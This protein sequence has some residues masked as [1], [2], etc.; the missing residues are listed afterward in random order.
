M[1]LKG[2]F[3]KV[4]VTK[5]LANKTAD[6]IGDVVES[7]RYHEADIIHEKRHIPDV[8]YGDPASFARYGSAEKYY[9]DSY[10]YIYSSYPYDGSLAEKLEW[11]N[12]GSYLDLHVFENEYPRTHGF[13]KFSYPTW[14]TVG[15]SPTWAYSGYGLPSATSKYEYI[16]LKGGPHKSGSTP[17]SQ[18]ANVWDPSN[19]RASNLELNLKKGTSVEFWLQKEAFDTDNSAKEVVFDLWNNEQSQSSDYGRFRV[20]LTGASAEPA[21]LLTV[22][23]GTA[24]VQWAPI[25][26]TLSS[27]VAD[28]KWHHYAFSAISASAGINVKYYVDGQLI[29]SVLTGS[30]GINAVSGAMTARIGSLIESP[31]GSIRHNHTSLATASYGKL[32]ASLDEFRYWKKKRSSEKIGRYW[33]TQVGGGTNT[34]YANVDLGVYYKFNE[35]I[36]GTSSIDSAVLDYSGRVTN[37][38]WTGYTAGART[39]GSA[40]IQ[41]S[42]STTEFKDP[43]M[44]PTHPKV[45]A[46]LAR[47]LDSGS[48]HDSLNPS[49]IFSTFPSWMQEQDENTTN[50][51]LKK[52]TQIISSYF[53]S[54]HL[55]IEEFGNLQDVRYASGSTKPNTLANR[56]L[57]SRGLHAPELFLDADIL[58]KLGDRSET[59][60][61]QESLTDVKNRIYQNIYNNLLNIYKSKGTR[62]SFRNVLRCY[63]VDEEI[64][65][66]NVYGNNISYEVRSNRELDSIK[67]SF[68]DFS[69]VDKHS[70]TIYQSGSGTAASYITGSNTLLAGFSTT[71]EAYAFF[72]QKP[73]PYESSFKYYEFAPLSSSLFG[74]HSIHPNNEATWD[75]TDTTNFEVYAV[76][77]TANSTDAQFVLT[78]SNGKVITQLTSSFYDE[79][80]ANSNWVFGVTVKPEKSPSANFVSGSVHPNKYILEFK[81]VNVEAG[82]VLESFNVSS[83]YRI[84]AAGPVT[85]RLITDS[86]KIYAGAHRTNFTGTLLNKSDVRIGF[87]R[88]WL[89]DL[90][91][92]EIEDHGKDVQNYGTQNPSRRAYLFEQS[93]SL[94][95]DIQDLDTLALNW[96]FE[97]VTGSSAAGN[98]LIPDFSSGSTS[99]AAVKYGG[100][101]GILGRRHTGG[102]YAFPVSSTEVVDVDYVLAAEL[103]NFETLNSSDMISVLDEDTDTL[104]TRESRP[105]NYHFSIEKSMYRSISDEMI[106]MF[107]T[108]VDFNNIVGDPIHKYRDYYKSLRILREKFFERVGNVPDL[109]KYIEFYKWFDSSLSKLLQQLV[110]A[111]ADFAKDVRNV[112]ESHVLERN[113]YQHKYPSIDLRPMDA[114]G[115]II[116][117]LPLSPGWEF[118]HHPL[119]NRQYRNGHWW[120]TRAKRTEGVLQT[121]NTAV[122]YNRKIMFNSTQMDTTREL[123]KIATD[124][125]HVAG[126]HP[127]RFNYNLN[128]S[129]TPGINFLPSKRLSFV[130]NATHDHGGDVPGTTSPQNI[131]VALA[132]QVQSEKDNIDILDPAKKK[133]K[134]FGMNPTINKNDTIFGEGNTFAPFSLYSSSVVSG[135]NKQVVES[136]AT[137]VALVDMHEDITFSGYQRPLQGPYTEALVGGR[138][139]RHTPLNVGTHEFGKADTAK[140]RAEGFR[141][142][143]GDVTDRTGAAFKTGDNNILA[144]VPPTYPNKPHMPSAARLR[145]DGIKRPVNIKNILLSTASADVVVTTALQH[146]KIGNYRMGYEVFHTSGRTSNDLYFRSAADHTFT[147]AKFPETTATRGR[148]PLTINTTPPCGAADCS[149]PN[150]SGNLDFELPTRPRQ[151]V[152]FVLKFSAPGSYESVSRGYLDPAHEEKSVYNVLPY[153]NLTVRSHGLTSSNTDISL[154]GSI[155]LRDQLGKPRGLNQ[156][157]SLY[158]AKYGQDPVY[159]SDSTDA[160]DWKPAYHQTP[161]N[162]VRRLARTSSALGEGTVTA[163]AYDTWWYQHEIPQSTSGYY[164]VTAS[165]DQGATIFDHSPHLSG[166]L[167]INPLPTISRATTYMQANYGRPVAELP[168]NFDWLNLTLY[169]PITSST[170][171]L[172]YSVDTQLS[173]YKK[174]AGV[175]IKPISPEDVFNN[176]ILKRNGPYQHPSWKQVRT[177]QHPVRRAQWGRNIISVNTKTAYDR[178]VLARRGNTIQQFVEPSVASESFPLVHIMQSTAGSAEHGSTSSRNM[179][180]VMKSAFGNTLN[181]FSNSGLNVSLNYTQ[182]RESGDLYFNRINSMLLKEYNND[183]TLQDT[184]SN[185]EVIY[186]QRVYP[187]SYNAYLARTRKRQN[188]KIDNIWYPKRSDRTEKPL[189]NNVAQYNSQGFQ[190]VSQSVWPLDANLNFATVAP[191]L[192]IVTGSGELQNNYHRYGIAKTGQGDITASVCYAWRCPTGLTSDWKIIYG[193]DSYFNSVPRLAPRATADGV[194]SVPYES[195]DEYCKNLTLIGKDYT[196]VPEFRMSKHIQSYVSGGASDWTT[197][198]GISDLLELSGSNYTSSATQGFFKDYA[199]SDFMKL[200]SLVDNTYEGAELLDTSIMTKDRFTLQCN[201]LVKPLPYKGFYPAERM[202]ELGTILSQSLEGRIYETYPTAYRTLLEPFSALLG[203]SIKSGLAVGTVVAG[204]G[205]AS[206]GS[207]VDISQQSVNCATTILPEGSVNFGMRSLLS[208]SLTGADNYYQFVRA[209]FEALYRFED[210]FGFN[211]SGGV[212][213][214]GSLYDTGVGSAS[215]AANTGDAY[216]QNRTIL[217]GPMGPLYHLAIDQFLASSLYWFI[218][219]EARPIYRASTP[220]PYSNRVKQGDTF[221][222]TFSVNRTLDKDTN[223]ADRSAFE[224]YSRAS[225][226]GAPF[227]LSKGFSTTIDS[228]A[229]YIFSASLAPH[230]PSYF[231][232]KSSATI[233]CTASYD[234]TQEL[235]DLLASADI[236]QNRDYEVPFSLDGG[237]H[238]SKT[239][240]GV[241]LAQQVTESFNLTKVI[242]TANGNQWVISPKWECP[243]L[244]FADSAYITPAPATRP[245]VTSPDDTTAALRVHS[246]GMWH[247]YGTLP[248]NAEGIYTNIS[249][250]T[251]ISSSQYGEVKNPRSLADLVGFPEGVQKRVGNIRNNLVVSEAVVAIPFLVGRDGRRKFYRLPASSPQTKSIRGNLD[252]YV[253]PPTL[254]FVRN[255]VMDPVVMYVFEFDITLTKSDLSDIWQNLLPRSFRNPNK[256]DVFVQKPTQ[257]I[258]H[259]LIGKNLLN[260]STRKLRDDLRWLVFKVKERAKSDYTKFSTSYLTEYLA[261][262]P[263]N[264]DTKYTYN[265]PND[266]LSI[267]E[268]I[269]IDEAVKYTAAI[270]VENTT[271]I[272]GDVN[273]QLQNKEPILVKD[274]SAVAADAAL[275]AAHTRTTIV[276]PGAV[277]QETTLAQR[278]TM[279][280]KT[281][282]AAAADK[283]EDTAEAATSAAIANLGLLR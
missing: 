274:V 212:I 263:S 36:T 56:L 245:I 279:T 196:L 170:N 53:D 217:R 211:S 266:Y 142:L 37:G 81:G 214:T 54:L 89:K 8:N 114:Q 261:N 90:T 82:E 120:R 27:E 230:L 107:A 109:D 186:S 24:G 148:F 80:Y 5:T 106:N 74:Q 203:N 132:S 241:A 199:N 193:G 270:P 220:S 101:G 52:L 200:F 65:K 160:A 172:G 18:S 145:G 269:K 191:V 234:G 177:W 237:R 265:W 218:D 185:V 91:I 6:E 227:V 205:L 169:E 180:L 104:F 88:Y 105:I 236:I 252:K 12:S 202:L 283:N 281:A 48:A 192:G 112:V 45:V 117:P 223:R 267:V 77:D 206:T 66:L 238:I 268:L 32:S 189:E 121:K 184:I 215:L 124:P 194:Y 255:P 14:G 122:D 176:L 151:E 50:T 126:T 62:K 51:E 130:F 100:L 209:P 277:A 86:R 93:A 143:F 113:K 11:Q 204:L 264:I 123:N 42:A 231:Y 278:V 102:A 253:F 125:T 187:A 161:R 156:L 174:P 140:T 20:E 173:H 103:Q 67:K 138:Q 72:P 149:T 99:T 46:N 2:L 40:I 235:G 9:Q 136:F 22:L 259:E 188:F 247:Q 78:S 221:A 98:F 10:T 17:Q 85:P 83:S 171:T 135:Y 219:P 181:G 282:G 84:S 251:Y 179:T 29:T 25:P 244:N 275:G 201:A 4:G 152:V 243:V 70:S 254:D 233:V 60:V 190:V 157:L 248:V 55:Q 49:Q 153:R 33:F 175:Y 166:G 273:V 96:D 271:R 31:S 262:I 147:F 197:L 144:V 39:T 258:S 43:I 58:E 246:L 41:S 137:G 276:V 178:E 165:M 34:D 30:T 28:G 95:L 150:I 154:S 141:I 3:E 232:G 75:P 208:A 38:T 108:I 195:Y 222:L 23:S 207:K 249:T 162:T 73:E 198:D 133:L 26:G 63:G 164:W 139:Y 128:R 68:I 168:A 159:A 226:F 111:G 57:E 216:V 280:T 240:I 61:Y 64:Y 47:L 213:G 94:N 13:V 155:A 183:S 163:S 35:G 71:V 134:Y 59:R 146:S 260:K 224:M 210:H 242:P 115:T 118:S 250:P 256:T 21:W 182:N 239:A 69:S 76:R 7:A 167:F 87:C 19:S 257:E 16:G 116:T 110:P 225:A 228:K 131:M 1:S 119:N 79:V 272:L 229:A 15:T 92:Q 129:I 97:T 44:Y 127:Y 158:T